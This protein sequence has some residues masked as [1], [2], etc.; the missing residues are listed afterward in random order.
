M[1]SQHYSLRITAAAIAAL[2][3]CAIWAPQVHA[4]PTWSDGAGN[5]CIACHGDFNSGTYV[6]NHDATSW[7]TNLMQGHINFMG[8]G[9]CN[10]C[11][12][13]PGG[14]PRTPVYIGLSAG[15]SPLYPQ[16]ACL[17]CHG[18]SNDA[19]GNCV[20]GNTATINPANCG[21]GTGLRLHHANSGVSECAGCHADAVPVGENAQPA[22]YFSDASRPSKPI[23]PCNLA[24]SPGNENKFGLTGLDN[25]GDLTYD[26]ADPDC[27]SA[28]ATPTST[29]VPATATPTSTPVPATPTPT[30]TPVPATPTPTSTP[31]PAT[32]TPTG[33]PVP[34]TPTPTSTPVPATPT[35]TGTPVPATPTPTSTPVPATPTPTSTPVPATPTPTGTPVPGTPTPTGTPVP[36]T[37][38]PTST[39]VPATPTPTSTPVPA[40]PTP[41]GTPVPATPTPTSTPVPAT[42][43]PTSPPTATPTLPP[44][45]AT[46]TP[47]EVLIDIKPGGDVNPINLKSHGVI[48]VAILGSADFSV[49]DL[50]RTTLRF[51]HCGNEGAAASTFDIKDVNRDG[52]PD[53][54]SHFR[55]QDTNLL[56][57]DTV[58]CLVGATEDGKMVHGTD[59]VKIL[60]GGSDQHRDDRKED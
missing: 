40:T 43:T 54:V 10:I 8:S 20:D 26:Q 48:P 41:T 39:P 49:M 44:P 14:T 46:P 25:D 27:S 4:Y 12:Q 23:D 6:S 50:N 57:G 45:T 51:G 58:A 53:L 21:M 34:A 38:T 17:G 9:A 11:H 37:P 30:S 19:T 18:R 56:M 2:V 33:T 16:I 35:P 59:V 36:G 31:V 55:T 60:K 7:G 32:P 29:P 3:S 24:P 42:A 28:T 1:K 22:Y 15:I 5:G 52:I 47:I 13:P